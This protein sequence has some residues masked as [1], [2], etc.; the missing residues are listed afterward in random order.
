MRTTVNH[1]LEHDMTNTTMNTTGA[2]SVDES[3]LQ[4]GNV[5]IL[6]RLLFLHT[7]HKFTR[8][9]EQVLFGYLERAI[10]F[11]LFM[12]FCKLWYFV[13]RRKR[14]MKRWKRHRWEPKQQ[15]NSPR[16]PTHQLSKLTNLVA[17]HPLSAQLKVLVLTGLG[18]LWLVSRASF[19]R[20]IKAVYLQLSNDA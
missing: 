13:F 1:N 12:I 19:L 16:D 10:I 15:E 3:F 11:E 18:S 8:N 4:V 9:F 14:N 6:K 7:L 17:W 2:S 20:M 5:S